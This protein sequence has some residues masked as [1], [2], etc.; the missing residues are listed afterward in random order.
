MGITG[1]GWGRG[2]CGFVILQGADRH[3]RVVRCV[4]AERVCNRR[5]RGFYSVFMII[6]LKLLRAITRQLTLQLKTPRPLKKLVFIDLAVRVDQERRERMIAKSCR[7]LAK[8]RKGLGSMDYDPHLFNKANSA[9][10][11]ALM[12]MLLRNYKWLGLRR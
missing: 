8:I 7:S 11:S 5:G 1:E 12:M 2:S 9:R 6:V 4:T 3:C 10:K